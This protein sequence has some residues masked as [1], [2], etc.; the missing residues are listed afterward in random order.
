M[1]LTWIH[2]MKLHTPVL[3]SSRESQ[4]ITAQTVIR[5]CGVPEIIFAVDSI[6][7]YLYPFKVIYFAV[8]ENPVIEYKGLHRTIVM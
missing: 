2:R 5:N 8:T 7:V 4:R 3:L 6:R 1:D